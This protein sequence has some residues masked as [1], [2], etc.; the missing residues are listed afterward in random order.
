[1]SMYKTETHLHTDESSSC[2]RV[3]AKELIRLYKEAG[4]TTV[5]V[6]DH[7]QKKG[8]A[9]YEA[10]AQLHEERLQKFLTGYYLAKEEGDKIGVNV[11]LGAEL[12]FLLGNVVDYLI[13]NFDI[14]VLRHFPRIYDMTPNEFFDFAN[15][16]G[17]LVIAAHPFRGSLH[18]VPSAVHGFEVI[19]ANPRKK[20]ETYNDLALA[21]ADRYGS[22]LRTGGSDAHQRI[23]VGAG[24]IMTEKPILTSEDYINVLKSK[25]YTIINNTDEILRREKEKRNAK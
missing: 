21:L 10:T 8:F 25:K 12:R 9:A 3:P 6:T 4:Y 23:D 24:G 13:Y 15:E 17:I 16:R 2:G 14:D 1:M 20:D 7:F 5:F 19:N 11:L 18:P 22:H